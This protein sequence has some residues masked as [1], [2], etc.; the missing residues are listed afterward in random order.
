VEAGETS[1]LSVTIEGYIYWAGTVG[2]D[3]AHALAAR[4]REGVQVKILL[5]AVGSATVGE[6]DRAL[7]PSDPS[8]GPIANRL[9][10][11]IDR[12]RQ[13]VFRA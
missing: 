4:A 5:D 8:I 1:L 11:P 7:Q 9:R 6:H 2:L 3:F 12:N 13:P 10:T